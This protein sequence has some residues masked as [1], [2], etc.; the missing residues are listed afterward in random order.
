[1]EVKRGDGSKKFV[2]LK[3]GMWVQNGAIPERILHLMSNFY[4]IYTKTIK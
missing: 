3:K 1:M 2:R 4:Y